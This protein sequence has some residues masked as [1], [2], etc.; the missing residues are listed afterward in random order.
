MAAIIVNMECITNMHVG[1][2]DVNFNI[3]DKEVERDVTTGYPTINASGLKGALRE[4]FEKNGVSKEDIS[5]IFGK[6]LAGK[7][8]FLCADMLALPMRASEGDSAYYLVTTPN[9]MQIYKEKCNM[10]LGKTISS[11]V[12]DNNEKRAAEGIALTKKWNGKEIY[13]MSEEDF[14]KTS[15]PVIARNC[16]EN[17]ISKN[18]W[19]EEVVPHKA[20]FTFA[21]L[22]QECDKEYLNIFK[23]EVNGKIVQFGGNASIGYGLCKLSVDEKEE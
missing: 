17:G 4:H 19:Y 18:L 6:E 23:N 2:G 8:K 16:L 1:N 14:K 22:A 13:V 7:L 20:L 11:D 9:A 5:A 21:V 3:I 10:F 15:L 12:V